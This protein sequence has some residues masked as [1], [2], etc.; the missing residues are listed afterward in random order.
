MNFKRKR[1]MWKHVIQFGGNF[2]ENFCYLKKAHFYRAKLRFWRSSTS[3]FRS[4]RRTRRP[5]GRT[6]GRLRRRGRDDASG[7]WKNKRFY[8]KMTTSITRYF[9]TLYDIV[10]EKI[11]LSTLPLYSLTWV[12]RQR[13]SEL[14]KLPLKL[15]TLKFSKSF[16]F[17]GKEKG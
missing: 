11:S 4:R 17:I 10:W 1:R 16:F 6:A 2:P 13:S 15:T 7:S 14:S 8:S 9:V 5:P 3:R 12:T